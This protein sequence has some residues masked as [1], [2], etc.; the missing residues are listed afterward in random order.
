MSRRLAALRRSLDAMPSPVLTRKPYVTPFGPAGTDLAIVEQPIVDGGDAGVVEDHCHAVEHSIEFQVG[1][2]VVRGRAA[3]CVSQG[4][5]S[6]ARHPAALRAVEHRSRERRELRRAGLRP[7]RGGASRGRRRMSGRFASWAALAMAVGL[8]GAAPA[9]GQEQPGAPT[10][11]AATVAGRPIAMKDVDDVVRAQLMDLRAR[12][13]QLRGQALDALVAQA[14]IEKEAEARGTTPE[15]L[16]EAEVESKAVVSE[17]EARTYYAA[18][19]SRF[20]TSPE[21]EALAQIKARLGQQRQGERRAALARELRAKYEVKVLLEPY[22]VPVEVGVAP[23]RGNPQAPVTIIEF[24]DFQCPYCVRARPA[25]ARVREVYGDRVRF[26]FRHFPL[27]FH[28]QAEKA[29]EAVACA[30]E[31]GK[32]WEMHD[33]LWTNTAKLQ[34]PDL[35][36]HAAT[37][38]VDRAAFGQCLDSGRYSHLVAGD[39]EAGQGYGVSGTP[40]FFVNGRPLVGAQPFEAFAQVIDDEL[41]RQGLTSPGAAAK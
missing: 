17:E 4:D 16:Y 9:P 18:N 28:Q 7:G 31:Q 21:A 29:G 13:H 19:K 14:L 34:V 26:A 30:G 36:A 27:D 20:G 3:V 5:G 1:S 6:A 37:L 2:Q 25:V 40:A 11:V 41:A 10:T 8:G 38:G 39:L 23:V 24:S 35:K 32:F 33:L 12:E 15:A 22:R